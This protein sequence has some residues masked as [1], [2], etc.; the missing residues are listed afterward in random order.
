MAKR[1]SY[2]AERHSLL[3]DAQYSGRPGRNTEQALLVLANAINRAWLKQKV[4]I[5]VAFNLKEAFNGVNNRSLD[6]RLK[7]K[8]IPTIVRNWIRSFIE[9]RLANITFDDFE[10][11]VA[12]LEN[13]GLA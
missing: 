11:S 12:S 8:E 9:N 2:Y 10:S 4:I 3:P 5:L 13:A 1:L 6:A 7:A